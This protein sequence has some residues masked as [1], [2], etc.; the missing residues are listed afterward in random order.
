MFLTFLDKYRDTGLLLLRVGLG[1]MF[2]YHGY[3]K[4]MGG[5]AGWEKLGSM[6][7]QYVGITA[8]PVFWGFMAACAEFF[9]GMLLIF[10]LFFRLACI[11]LVCNMA[12][13]VILKFSTGLGLAG[14][15][16]ALEDGIVFLNLI[17]I[18][19]GKY[20]LDYK[21]S[22]STNTMRYPRKY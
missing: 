22:K 17:L 19:P 13:A 10:G 12:L 8:Y 11:M 16:P 7:M 6:A 21:F 1:L 5:E 9:G 4:I 14:A 18:G 3:P 2:I 15:A 20:S